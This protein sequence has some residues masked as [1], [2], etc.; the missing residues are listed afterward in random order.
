MEMFLAEGW[1]GRCFHFGRRFSL[2]P[3]KGG[4]CLIRLVSIDYFRIGCRGFLEFINDF[5]SRIASF[6]EVSF[7]FDGWFGVAGVFVE[8]LRMSDVLYF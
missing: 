1:F 2:I 6:K 3:K 7:L 8:D 4:E 5:P